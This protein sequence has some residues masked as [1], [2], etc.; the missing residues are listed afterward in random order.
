MTEDQKATLRLIAEFLRKVS[1]AVEIPDEEIFVP[2]EGGTEWV[3]TC[4]T[5]TLSLCL[6]GMV[7]LDER[8]S[9]ERR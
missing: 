5:Y 8:T 4:T 1:P 9:S 2:L 7:L 6:E 3:G